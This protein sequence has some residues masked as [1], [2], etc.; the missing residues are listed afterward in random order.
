MLY[1]AEQLFMLRGWQGRVAEVGAMIEMSA[2]TP[3]VVPAWRCTLAEYYCISD[4]LVE[5]RREFDALA[6]DDFSA[7]PRDATWLGAMDLLAS[8]CSRLHDPARAAVLY[9]LLLPFAGRIAVAWPLVVV[10][11]IVDER[12]GMLAG[13][14]G[15]YETAETHFHNALATAERMRALPWQIDIRHQWAAMLLHRDST[16]SRKQAHVLL[17]QAD[18]SARAIG[19][20]LL[21][22][23]IDRTRQATRGGDDAIGTMPA[24][25]A[26]GSEG[27]SAPAQR[28]GAFRR[29]G[30]VWSIVFEGRTTRMRDM[31]GLAHIARLLREPERD[32]H[33]LDLAAAPVAVV[34]AAATTEEV[35]DAQA[36]STYQK[37]LR[38]AHEELAEAERLND[39]GQAER[40]SQEIE[41]LGAELSRA[42]G[43]GGRARRVNQ[44]GERARTAVT[45]AIKYAVDRLGEH[46]P[47]LAEHLRVAVRTGTFCAYVPP[48]R[49]KVRWTL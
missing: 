8:I 29:D 28:V 48:A 34:A 9:E 38:D 18:A 13:T 31:L 46:D 14:L 44:T 12:L 25:A 7:I 49:D 26:I 23:W 19:M 21:L 36:R 33:V 6:A 2:S 43:L 15:R 42:L 24:P 35:L 47:A 37:R 1:H 45:R 16:A 3:G 40:L 4:R 5:A 41:F 20:T 10:M 30:D 32:V 27:A 39:R 11:G 17:D 22:D